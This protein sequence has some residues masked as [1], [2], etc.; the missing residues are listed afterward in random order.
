MAGNLAKICG[1]AL[2]LVSLVSSSGADEPET[3][4]D[5]VLVNGTVITV[6]PDLPRA[7][8][9]AARNQRIVA[10][11]SSDTVR[12]LV[13]PETRVIDLGGR[14]AIP[15]F[16]EGHGHLTSLGEARLSLDLS[17]AGDWNEVVDLV[18]KAAAK[19]APGEWI[20]G[21][22][23]HQGRWQKPP[24]PDVEGYPVH[25]RLSR[26][27]PDHPV[28]LKHATGHMCFANA[29]A[30]QLAQIDR[31]TP[32]PVGGQI[33]RDPAGAA[34]GAFREAAQNRIYKAFEASQAGRSP[35]E[36]EARHRRGIA[37]AVDECLA[38]GV[39]S[40]QDAGASFE[41]I[42]LFKRLAD[43]QQL[44]LRLWV[45]V[46]GE[47]HRRLGEQLARG[48]LIGYADQHLTVRAI[49]CMVD[50]ALG[51][52]GAWLFQP[53]D[54][55][56]G[57]TGLVV[58]SLES[59][60]ETA[61]LA[62]KA[63][64]QLCTHAIGDRANHEILN[65]YDAIFRS[66]PA[67]RD[68]RWR[69]EHAQHILPADFPRFAEL[70]VIASMQGNHATSDG[71]FVVARLGQQRGGAESYAWRS[72]LDHHALVINGT[73]VPVEDV[74]PILSFYASVTRRMKDGRTFF[75]EQCMTREEALRSYTQGAAF[76]A[77]EDDLKGTLS[78]GKLA[79]VVVL[80]Q[81]I[82]TVPEAEIP[83]ARVDFTI[84]GGR[85]AFERK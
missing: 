33:L 51:S 68:W 57:S 8:G 53:Y 48:R 52:H 1:G 71:P 34:T 18:A 54:D 59:I 45:M 22:G 43:E 20:V 35:A 67:R 37:L 80:S 6:D 77:F 27:T 76:A 78:V 23:W 10:V 19:T 21:D 83:S 5:I 17:Q 14:L 58:E 56:P 79:D 16:I 62:A 36:R 82:L 81:N 70:G 47:S 63:D 13:G 29:R 50:G 3:P 74:N 60:R 32:N 11:G 64:Y 75:P 12:R 73:D 69:I 28:L 41:T 26:A 15:G 9:L 66:Q 39:T 72:L 38:K 85:V 2:L 55:L 25:E 24:L 4:A 30:M 49:K 42:N 61:L 46:R 31:D 65:L 44:K 40:F 84:V 7:Q